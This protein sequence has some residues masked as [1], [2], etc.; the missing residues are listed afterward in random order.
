ML[1]SGLDK[2]SYRSVLPLLYSWIKAQYF[3]MYN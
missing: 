2:G 3:Q 1:P